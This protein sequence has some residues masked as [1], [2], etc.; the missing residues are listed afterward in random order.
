MAAITIS[1]PNCGCKLQ[2]DEQYIGI[3]VE[4]PTCKKHFVVSS[5]QPSPLKIIKLE[6][7]VSHTAAPS[8][9]A[10]SASMPENQGLRGQPLD[11]DSMPISLDSANG[12]P[13]QI[14]PMPSSPATNEHAQ[15]AVPLIAP[16]PQNS[17]TGVPRPAVVNNSVNIDKIT[18]FLPDAVDKCLST[19]RKLD[20][21]R[22]DA[23]VRD[24][25][26]LLGVAL[27]ILCGLLGF[28]Y[29]AIIAIKFK[30]FSML[31][32]GVGLVVGAVLFSAIS[33]KM[34]KLCSLTIQ[35]NENHTSSYVFFDCLFFILVA[36]SLGS[37][38]TACFFF[39]NMPASMYMQNLPL[40]LGGVACL[41]VAILALKPNILNI[42]VSKECSAG[43]DYLSILNFLLKGF[44]FIL[45]YLWC[46]GLLLC[47]SFFIIGCPVALI[48][49]GFDGNFVPNLTG[50]SL[51]MLWLGSL[52]FAVYLSYLAINFMFD[53]AK[54][55]L[56]IPKKI[57]ELK[58]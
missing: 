50:C 34:F 13:A 25:L 8:Q 15:G 31:F 53:L 43:E 5:E 40:V 35:K 45:P 18:N 16:M 33:I 9:G 57:D 11:L 54:A 58:K 12:A 19:C 38:G 6:A 47:F 56:V 44:L 42:N 41:C 46:I 17:D 28:F 2:A 37:I 1:C 26:S 51:A 55:V 21:E 24:K 52:P 22:I 10:Q 32:P 20:I 3:E 27:F 23:F 36:S 48:M 4:C 14:T 30:T 7:P 39:I 29:W 49:D